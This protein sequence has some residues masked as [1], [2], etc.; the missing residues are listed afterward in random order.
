MAGEIVITVIGNLTDDPE[1]RFVGQS[2]AAVTNF[3]IAQTARSYR[4]GKWEES[5]TVFMRCTAWKTDAEHI[6]DSLGKGDRVIASGR[7]SQREYET[8]QGEKRTVME[9]TVDEIGPS[10]KWATA[11]PVKV[12]SGNGSSSRSAPASSGAGGFDDEPPF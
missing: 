12:K 5:G 8:K 11:K 2:S 10:L 7:L 4:D 9:L 3:T 6:V 1:M